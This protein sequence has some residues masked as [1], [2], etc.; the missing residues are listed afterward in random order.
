MSFYLHKGRC[1]FLHEVSDEIVGDGV[2]SAL[3]EG[4]EIVHVEDDSGIVLTLHS[5]L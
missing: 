5:C 1:T 2:E 4:E 3:E